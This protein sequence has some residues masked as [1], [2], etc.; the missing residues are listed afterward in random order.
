MASDLQ[1]FPVFTPGGINQGNAQPEA[2]D[3]EEIKNFVAY[4]GR[5]ALRGPIQQVATSILDDQ[6]SPAVVTA[7]LD[8]VEYGGLVYMATY[9]S[10][11]QKVY[12]HSMTYAGG[13]IT[14]R[15]T[16]WASATKPCVTLTTMTGGTAEVPVA[17][18]FACDYAGVLATR[19]WDGAALSTVTCDLD[20]NSAAESLYFQ[21]MIEYKFHLWG[22]GYFEGSILRPEMIRF[23]QPGMIPCD[24]VAGGTN[25]KEWIS[26]DHRE[27]GR[28]GNKIRAAARCG[29]RMLL[30]QRDASHAIFGSSS[31]TWTRQELSPS[32]GCIGPRAVANADNRVVYFWSDH[33][34]YRTDGSDVQFIGDP[35]QEL[36][37]DV[38]ASETDTVVAFSPDEG[39]VYWVI[40][41]TGA[42]AYKLVL[43]FD[44][45][46]GRWLKAEYQSGA[47]T[48]YELGCATAMLNSTAMGRSM[49]FGQRDAS[50]VL[51]L[52]RV[53]YD[54]AGNDNG[55][56]TYTGTL[57][58]E[59]FSP[60]GPAGL[61]NFRKV[62]VHL[63]SSGTFNVTLKV[64]VDDVRTRLGD[65]TTQTIVITGA[66]AVEGEYALEAA[67]EAQGKHIRVELTADSN[68]NTAPF[69]I[70]AITAH[71][72]AVRGVIGRASETT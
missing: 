65:G 27:V 48:F 47:S 46:A 32:V 68:V 18:L 44:H 55:S 52:N 72:R 71:G 69:F 63:Y 26:A 14:N 1:V 33:G 60:A 56:H 29:D 40:T 17:R 66:T 30:F 39:L 38:D 70:E 4:R 31:T 19:M 2:T 28:R 13:S 45:R 24:D 53:G 50:R 34:P 64:W 67:I 42:N 6:G 7:I 57:R 3:A 22:T 20:N 54:A 15:G 9:S 62:V 8:M 51:R 35:I 36:I 49:Y 21:L 37:T 59:R 10:V 16:L 43:V 5:L 25:P 41:L 58:T 11:T 61:V 23:S 12:L